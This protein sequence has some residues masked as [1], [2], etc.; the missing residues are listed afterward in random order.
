MP[1]IVIFIHGIGSDSNTWDDLIKL[2]KQDKQSISEYKNGIHIDDK[3]YFCKY[4]YESRITP[5]YINQFLSYF[6]GKKSVD[7]KNIYNFVPTLQTFISELKDFN[8]IDIVAHSMGGILVMEILMDIL[9]KKDNLLNKIENIFFYGVPF[10]GSKE[11]KKIRLFSSDT[12]KDLK[13]NSPYIN[14]L[15]ININNHASELK[16]NFN[17]FSFFGSNDNRIVECNRDFITTFSEYYE[18][19]KNHNTINKPK[20]LSDVNY[21]KLKKNIFVNNTNVDEFPQDIKILIQEIL[22]NAIEHGNTTK[23]ETLKID[24]GILLKYDGTNFNPIEMLNN[25]DAKKGGT[26]TIKYVLE[27]LN[28]LILIH[29]Y[30]DNFNYFYIYTKNECY[31]DIESSDYMQIRQFKEKLNTFIDNSHCKTIIIDFSKLK[32]IP[33][34]SMLRIF[35][36]NLEQ[37]DI[38]IKNKKIKIIFKEHNQLLENFLSLYQVEL[39]VVKKK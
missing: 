2:I 12:L 19:D 20:E 11:P 34:P 18:L 33:C 15:Y 26:F 7:T 24:N 3:L 27:K 22:L 17:I 25:T 39:E 14:N 37:Q 1:K 10:C 9:D 16:S 6:N 13:N 36:D 35:L 23:H 30:K 38:K 5:S 32:N 31:T 21:S 4:E 8:K 28:N 29:E